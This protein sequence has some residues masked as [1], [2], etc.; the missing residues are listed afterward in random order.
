MHRAACPQQRIISPKCPQH[1]GWETLL[2]YTRLLPKIPLKTKFHGFRHNFENDCFAANTKR[3]QANT[4]KLASRS[5]GPGERRKSK[6][7]VLRTLPWQGH[8]LRGNEGSLAHWTLAQARLHILKAIM[9]SSHQALAGIHCLVPC[10]STESYPSA[11][12]RPRHRMEIWNV[13]SRES[14]Q[15]PVPALSPLPFPDTTESW[16]CQEP[17]CNTAP[18]RGR[19]WGLIHDNT[20]LPSR[21]WA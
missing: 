6:A 19:K 12:L 3:P 1:R 13:P 9:V 8:Y 17:I 20:E 4:K 7:M 15:C 14:T 18:E 21:S 16:L 11:F 2:Y 10:P 5:Q